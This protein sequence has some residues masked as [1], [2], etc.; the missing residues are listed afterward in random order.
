MKRK[1]PKGPVAHFA[2]KYRACPTEEQYAVMDG[3]CHSVR[4]M[5][6]M[7]LSDRMNG[8]YKTP[9]QYKKDKTWLTDADSLALCDAQRNL[10]GAFSRYHESG[11][12][13]GYR[14]S[15]KKLA[16]AKRTGKEL[17][18]PY[19][20]EGHPKY[21]RRGDA[22]HSYTTYCSSVGATNLLVVDDC[23]KLPKVGLLKVKLHRQPPEG[24]V[25]T[26]ATVEISSTGKVFISCHFDV[27]AAPVE[28]ITEIREDRVV[29]LDF[30]MNGLYTSSDGD[31]ANMPRRYRESEK[32][33]AK[34]QK[35]LSRRRELAKQRGVD[36]R[37]A[38]NYQKQKKKVASIHE[39]IANQRKDFLHKESRKIANSYDL[40][41][42]EDLN[43]RGMAGG[44]KLGKSVHDDGW[45]M[46]TNFLGY[47]LKDKGGHLIKV[48]KWFPSSRLCPICGCVL[49]KKELP[50][51]KRVFE[52]RCG[53]INAAQNVKREALRMAEDL[54][55][56]V[57]L[58]EQPKPVYEEGSYQVE[59]IAFRLANPL[60]TG[61][62]VSDDGI[63]RL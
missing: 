46:F 2:A 24:A 30:M 19:D 28:P 29:G 48:D 12:K 61:I 45:G 57:L 8:V 25:L 27:P 54:G 17:R 26:S 5:Y 10:N 38:K 43:M 9:A 50:L 11:K 35:V 41:G 4:A 20:L 15:K 44:L 14:Y 1:T 32:K 40:V 63:P 56:T 39:R 21:K 13:N 3:V 49:S 36:I 33:L 52:C 18:H 23:I 51:S 53:D 22:K 7:S 37:D 58:D 55:I 34:A 62:S 47:K 31:F 16:K 59:G 42:I 60:L 6:N